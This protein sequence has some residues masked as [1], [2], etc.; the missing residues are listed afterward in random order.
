[1][2]IIAPLVL[3]ISLLIPPAS[4]G[5][6]W[7]VGEIHNQLQ[8]TFKSGVQASYRATRAPCSTI[9]IGEGRALYRTKKVCYLVDTTRPLMVRSPWLPITRKT[10]KPRG[11]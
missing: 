2:E 8:V 6:H 1:M 7:D 9:P 11:R 10:Y 5:V 3:S 4:K